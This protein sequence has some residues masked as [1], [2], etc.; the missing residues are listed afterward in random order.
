MINH[1]S[2]I[3]LS[4]SG[5]RLYGSVDIRMA[6]GYNGLSW[7]A[8]IPPDLVE[9]LEKRLDYIVFEVPDDKKNDA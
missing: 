6:F 5:Q 3:T 1:S 4:D 7:K 2:S 8:T 9:I